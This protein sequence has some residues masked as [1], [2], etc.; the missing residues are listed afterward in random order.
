MR[1]CIAGLAFELRCDTR[2]WLSGLCH[3]WRDFAVSEQPSLVIQIILAAS[4][5]PSRVLPRLQS[6]L[7]EWVASPGGAFE[8]RGETFAAHI[9]ADRQRVSI[10]QGEDPIVIEGVV[11]VLVAD[12]LGQRGGLLVHG[13]GLA[14]HSGAAAVFVGH[15]G[16]G[17][18]TL[19]ALGERVG[20][21]CLAD[22]LVA[23]VPEGEGYRALGTPWNR[24][25]N[26]EGRLNAVG[27]LSHASVS[28]IQGASTAGLLRMLLPNTLI[29][30]RTPEGRKQAFQTATRLLGTVPAIELRFAPDEAAARLL[31]EHLDHSQP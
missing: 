14:G 4:R 19:G 3:A 8:L 2:G 15:S 13:V 6:P 1:F 26:A 22:E 30:D 12:H 21:R 7:P 31:A 27:L 29:A 28:N 23:L 25:R 9:S 24:G 5:P 18:S 16:A 17:K 11:R 20:L 10:D